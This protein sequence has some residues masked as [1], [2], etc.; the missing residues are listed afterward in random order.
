MRLHSALLL[1]KTRS[2]WVHG[3]DI[4]GFVID[5]NKTLSAQSSRSFSSITNRSIPT[6]AHS[7]VVHLLLLRQAA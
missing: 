1:G 6:P 4:L 5:E 7:V 2:L 3:T